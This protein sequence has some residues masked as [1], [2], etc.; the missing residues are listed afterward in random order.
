MPW[1]SEAGLLLDRDGRAW[2]APWVSRG[3]S[4]GDAQPAP[5][6]ASL[7]AVAAAA[8][9]AVL[10]FALFARAGFRSTMVEMTREGRPPR[11][12]PEP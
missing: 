10:T 2:A 12:V 3:G 4:L 5:T 1:R 11:K 8:V 6:R 7:R 9:L